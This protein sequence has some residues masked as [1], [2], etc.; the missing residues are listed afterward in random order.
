M[1]LRTV[2]FV[3]CFE[4]FELLLLSP[5]LDILGL[6]QLTFSSLWRMFFFLALGLT[7]SIYETVSVR[8][9]GRTYEKGCGELVLR[10]GLPAVV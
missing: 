8:E 3:L 2:S 4:F 5:I 6:L 7:P 1:F 10:L 9:K